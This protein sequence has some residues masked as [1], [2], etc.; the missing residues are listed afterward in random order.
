M[1]AF[2]PLLGLGLTEEQK[3]Q[4]L[5]QALMSSGGA[6]LSNSNQPGGIPFGK[7]AQAL[8]GSLDQQQQMALAAQ[9]QALQRKN[10]ESQM[11]Y[12]TG[13]EERANRQMEMAG[14]RLGFEKDRLAIAQQQAQLQQQKYEREQELISERKKGV[15]DFMGTMPEPKDDEQRL[16]RQMMR[17]S[18]LYGGSLP[19]QAGNVLMPSG[20]NASLAD[21]LMMGMMGGTQAGGQMGGQMPATQQQADPRVDMILKLASPKGMKAISSMAAVDAR[22]IMQ[23]IKSTAP[24]MS[25]EER[26]T[27]SQIYQ[28][29]EERIREKERKGM[30]GTIKR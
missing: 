6:M 23:E 3:K 22:T 29:L 24:S 11:Q 12:R 13:E 8:M 20:R 15:E 26:A 5:A 25:P 7:G 9:M 18:M 17:N 14:K 1:N 16:A 27:A 2:N 10:M 21:Q 28:A 4:M 19:S 30:I